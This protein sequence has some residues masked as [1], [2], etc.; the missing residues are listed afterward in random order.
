M[1]RG[2]KSLKRLLGG[3]TRL[4]RNLALLSMKDGP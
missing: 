4:S 1:E 2:C 3:T